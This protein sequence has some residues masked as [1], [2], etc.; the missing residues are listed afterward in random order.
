MYKRRQRKGYRCR[1]CGQPAEYRRKDGSHAGD[2][3]H[4]LCWSCFRKATARAEGY[5]KRLLRNNP[6]GDKP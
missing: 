5:A 4:D 2:K 6:I 1:H 3:D